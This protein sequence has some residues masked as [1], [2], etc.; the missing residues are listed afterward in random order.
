MGEPM[1][2]DLH[3]HSLR[4]DGQLTPTDLV[5]RAHE[6]GVTHLALTDHDT[7]NGLH[8]AKQAARSL[9][10]EIINGIEISTVWNGMGIHVVGLNFDVEHPAMLAAIARQENCRLERAKTIAQKLEKQGAT[11]IWEAAQKVADGAQIG[12]PHFAQA[13]IDMGKVNN[14]AA[15]FKRYLGAGKPGDVKTLWPE[16]SEAVQWIVDA[17]GTAVLAH[18][19][20]YKLTRTKLRLLLNAFKEAGGGA[21]EVTTGGMES[22]FAQRM[23]QYCDEFDLLG[24]QG[25]DF[26]GPR[27][28]SELGKF[29]PMPKSVTP[30]WHDWYA[31]Q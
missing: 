23:A 17:G 12:R 4:S 31:D 25:S 1:L 11:G 30:V 19:D 5:N 6:R 8:E 3:C 14:M 20:K 13:L 2:F 26:H 9:G 24:S 21:V 28:W 15:A 16:M 7:I 10:L 22:S 27:P 29:P 18:P